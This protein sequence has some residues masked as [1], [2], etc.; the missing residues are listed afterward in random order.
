ML[1]H[2]DPV[3][4]YYVRNPAF[5]DICKHGAKEMGHFKMAGP[6]LVNNVTA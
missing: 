4:L 2:D 6:D 3:L 5:I 1:Q